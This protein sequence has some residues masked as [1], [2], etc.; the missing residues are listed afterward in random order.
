MSAFTSLRSLIAPLLSRRGRQPSRHSSHRQ[1]RP[2]L[3]L[4][5]DR[6]APATFTVNLATDNNVAFA[7]TSGQLDM[8]GQHSGANSGDLRWCA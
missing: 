2:H 5:E 4:L 6:L 7:V 1:V 3:E 8:G